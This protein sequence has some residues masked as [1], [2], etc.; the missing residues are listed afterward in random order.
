MA[1][2]E[3]LLHTVRRLLDTGELEHM[4]ELVSAIVPVSLPLIVE[5]ASLIDIALDSIIQNA[6]Y[7]GVVLPPRTPRVEVGGKRIPRG[8]DDERAVLISAQHT[9]WNGM[10]EK[11][12]GKKYLCVTT[13][14]GGCVHLLRKERHKDVVLPLVVHQ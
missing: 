10:L 4:L 11:S 3:G 6:P 12:N 5:G 2:V 8:E 9:M 1:N 13:A 14:V 7:S